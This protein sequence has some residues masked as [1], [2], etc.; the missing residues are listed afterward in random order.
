MKGPEMML[1]RFPPPTSPLMSALE[2][3]GTQDY[4]SSLEARVACLSLQVQQQQGSIT[5]LQARLS[6]LQDVQQ[7]VTPAAPDA[8]TTCTASGPKT[9]KPQLEWRKEIE[10]SI[11]E[12]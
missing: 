10:N 9:P 3:V 2:Q 11:Y 8:T 1:G 6:A 4:V 7:E 12:R 5:E